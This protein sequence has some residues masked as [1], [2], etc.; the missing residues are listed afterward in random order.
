MGLNKQKSRL[1]SDIVD[2]KKIWRD[3]V[4]L[5]TIIFVLLSLLIFILY[6]LYAVLKVSFIGNDGFTL[7][8]Y[9]TTL[10]SLEFRK[11]LANT[12][13]L[14]IT[15]GLLSTIIGFIFAYA[16]SYIKTHFKKLFK[17]VSIL[18]IISPPFVLALSSIMLFGQYGLITRR[19]FGIEDANIYGFKGLVLVQTMTFFP[20]AY[21][22]LTGLL[23]NIDPSLEEASRD[24]GA[25]RWKTF[26]T[27]TLPL[28]AP[29]LANS[30]LLTF[31]ETVA[32]FSN[33]MVIGGNFST[34][35]TQIY[36]QAIGN[37]DMQGGAT[38][39]VILL[40]L[41]I[42]LF[43]LEKYWIERKTYVTVTGKASRERTP[44]TEKKI[45]YPIDLI[46]LLIT[47]FVLSFYV[48][49]PISAFFNVAGVDYTLTTKHFKYVWELGFKAVKDTT[50]LSAIAT[51]ITGVLGMVIAFLI[52]RKKF[53]GRGFI[54]FTSLLAMA[55]PGTV[56]GIGYVSAYNT[57]PLVLTGTA[58]IIIISFVMRSVPV[59]VRSGVASLQQIDPSIEEA[60]SD[61]GASSTKVF[62]SITLPLI[63]NAF[64]SGLVYTFVR[65]MTAVSAV[66]FLVSARYSLLT[67]QILSQVDTGRFG[68]ASAYSTILIIIV[69]IAISILYFVLG[70][71]GV[72]KEEI[73]I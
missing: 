15:V 12:L 71:L 11:T 19:I 53:F 68:V 2:M 66:I 5:V 13:I 55:V 70:K 36:M 51:P 18:P 32:D 67:V 22:L 43:V 21:L 61:L 69:Y 35:A 20:V 62:T 44:I 31:I 40:V 41:S 45:V 49:I 26:T 56:I 14:G 42:L 59:G 58:A 57:K 8:A 7:D 16:D 65:S 34:L 72:S 33:P 27:V 30:F 47:V 73:E 10:K 63:K 64:F 46:C 29:G 50:L 1:K 9:I 39:A 25:S 6:P 37:Y 38:V 54:E 4:L 60:A 28:M 48:L 17:L 52:V 23:K 3:P 24:M